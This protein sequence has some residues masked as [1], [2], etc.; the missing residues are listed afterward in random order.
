MLLE[1]Y[2]I[3]YRNGI[4]HRDIRPSNIFFTYLGVN[5]MRKTTKEKHF[6][7]D[8]NAFNN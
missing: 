7:N 3:L 1:E 2:K 6:D 4:V 8:F 5:N